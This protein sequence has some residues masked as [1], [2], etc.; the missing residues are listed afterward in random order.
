M[1]IAMVKLF[2]RS[3]MSSKLGTTNLKCHFCLHIITSTMATWKP[4]GL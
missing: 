4:S 2:L 1:N 3:I